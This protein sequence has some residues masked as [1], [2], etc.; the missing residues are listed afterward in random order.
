MARMGSWIV[1]QIDRKPLIVA[2]RKAVRFV[3]KPLILLGKHEPLNQWVKGKD[4]CAPTIAQIS[5]GFSNLKKFSPDKSGHFRDRGPP[6]ERQ[7][8]RRRSSV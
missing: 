1:L 6:D 3:T 5:F 4:P 8:S 7:E 2:T